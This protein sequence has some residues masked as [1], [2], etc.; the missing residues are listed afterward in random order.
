[1]DNPNLIYFGMSLTLR[2]IDN[3]SVEFKPTDRLEFFNHCCHDGVLS[4]EYGRA[5][6]ECRNHS[7]VIRKCSLDCGMEYN[8]PWTKIYPLTSIVEIVKKIV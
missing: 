1:M 4:V 7:D 3:T 5:K 8:Y 2:L 6:F